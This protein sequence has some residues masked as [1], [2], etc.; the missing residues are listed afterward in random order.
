MFVS[1]TWKGYAHFCLWHGSEQPA[2]GSS[3]CRVQLAANGAGVSSSN[4]KVG[5]YLAGA[6]CELRALVQDV[7]PV[8]QHVGVDVVVVLRRLRLCLAL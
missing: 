6:R 3:P 2:A 7:A 4:P 1:A 8:E 5:Q